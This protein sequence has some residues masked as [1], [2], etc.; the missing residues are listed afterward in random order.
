MKKKYEK[1]FM[2]FVSLEHGSHLL[3]TSGELDEYEA[4]HNTFDFEEDI[5]DLWGDDEEE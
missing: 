3:E 5:N 1:P 4:K 2:F